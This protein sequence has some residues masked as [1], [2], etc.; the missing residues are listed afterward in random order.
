[1]ARPAFK[2]NLMIFVI[3][4]GT[5]KLSPHI[6][7]RGID[8]NIVPRAPLTAT[9]VLAG[10]GFRAA[11]AIGFFAAVPLPLPPAR[12]LSSRR[13]SILFL[14]LSSQRIYVSTPRR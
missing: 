1:M 7:C 9:I 6:C 12:T 2:A 14:V 8:F 11:R 4:S 10:S 5:V 13:L 3:G